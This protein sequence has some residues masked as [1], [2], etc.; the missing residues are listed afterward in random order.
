MAL[1]DND[2]K[3]PA[4]DAALPEVRAYFEE[5][6][7]RSGRYRLFLELAVALVLLALVFV[8]TNTNAHLENM[9][10]AMEMQIRL[11]E[12]QQEQLKSLKKGS[13]ESTGKIKGEVSN[14][15]NELADALGT[16]AEQ[17]RSK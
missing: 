9:A 3:A 5:R 1:K 12:L 8:V 11:I 4:A 15:L 16:A 2:I 14:K 13:D 6:L 17:L 10:N 7:N